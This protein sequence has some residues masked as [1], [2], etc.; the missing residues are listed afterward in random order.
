MSDQWSILIGSARSIFQID[1]EKFQLD[2]QLIVTT[3]S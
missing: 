1:L 2:N 3:I